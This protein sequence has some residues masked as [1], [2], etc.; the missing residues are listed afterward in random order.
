MSA[1]VGVL[2]GAIATYAATA[3]TE[4]ARWHRMQS[5]RWDE[6]RIN[7]YTEYA[8]VLKQVITTALR[9]AA[10]REGRLGD[11]GLPSKDELA[12]LRRS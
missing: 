2:V 4:R 12:Y 8:H 6:K 7:V 5:V 1:L 9:I 3:A 10:A 11:Q